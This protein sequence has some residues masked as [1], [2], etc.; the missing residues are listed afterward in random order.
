VV[1]GRSVEALAAGQGMRRVEL[2]GQHVVAVL[3]AGMASPGSHPTRSGALVL[4]TIWQHIRR[5]TFCLPAAAGPL[6]AAVLV[7][8]VPLANGAGIVDLGVADE[9]TLSQP[10]VQIAVS[11]NGRLFDIAPFNECLLDTGASGILMARI[12]SQELRAAGLVE[13]ATYV[14]FG[15]AGPQAT[16]VSAAYDFAFA[17]SDG[18]PLTMSDVRLQTSGSDFAFY[19]GIA[20]M[21][22]MMGRTVGLDLARQADME[23]LR[24]GVAFG[25]APLP[26][27]TARQYSIPLS[28]YEFPMTGRVNPDDPL[29]I[30]AP[31][32]FAPV[33]LQYGSTRHTTSLLVDTGAQQ[34]ILSST[35]AFELGLDLNGNGDLEDEAVTFQEVI[36]VGGTKIIPVLQ[37]DALA[38]RAG[39]GTDLVFRDIAVGIIDIDDALPGVLGMN[40]LNAGWEIYQLNTFLGIEPVGPPGVLDRVDFDFRDAAAT[41]AADMRLTVRADADVAVSQGPLT[42][43]VTAGSLG[44]SAAGHASIGGTGTLE[45]TGA[46]TLVLDAVNTLSGPTTVAAGSLEIAAAKGLFGSPVTV[47]TGATLAIADGVVARVPAVTL[48]GGT[49]AADSLAIDAA[50]GI[51]RLEVGDGAVTGPAGSNGPAVSVGVVG[52]LVLAADRSNV[53]EVA[54]LAVDE[55]AGG[56]VDLGGGRI[57]IAAGASEEDLR[58]DILAGR[59]DGTWNGAAGI[60]STAVAT[61]APGTRTIGYRVAA[62]GS[63]VVA[64]AAPG[65]L[66]L[67]GIVDMSDLAALDA[68]GRYGTGATAGWSAGDVNYD[69]V[70]NL[71]D[72]V[73]I[74][75]AGGFGTGRSLPTGSA[76][77]GAT[78]VAVPEPG[79]LGFMA[80]AA[81]TVWAAIGRR[82]REA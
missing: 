27:P 82:P 32:P 79:L 61:A 81:A 52:R 63:A 29:P 42:V 71:F 20:G 68:A 10:I 12:A 37:I 41:M 53:L 56:L 43:D 75:A 19:S 3:P 72:L 13:E 54:S 35:T 50:V 69:G 55:A 57:E 80:L 8:A 15:V 59:G 64:V 17:G 9:F 62:D 28:M 49:L 22:L 60:T 70:V 51:G 26:A 38:L 33:E 23:A 7:A 47:E 40:I 67:D 46:G 76:G 78:A 18:V 25:S 1:I 36:G 2:A 73:A 16:G 65:D 24:M 30:Y 21:P 14:D 44:Q 4:K 77:A 31:L 66:D 74:Q 6:V 48:A 11:D 34:C 45:K 5:R 39:D 58:A